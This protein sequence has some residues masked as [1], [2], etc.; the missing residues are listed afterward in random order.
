MVYKYLCEPGP[1]SSAFCPEK[2]IWAWASRSEGRPGLSRHLHGRG[3]RTR[4]HLKPEKNIS[5]R[6]K[7]VQVAPRLAE[8]SP[9]NTFQ[10]LITPFSRP[11]A[12]SRLLLPL[13]GV[14]VGR[15]P[16]AD[17]GGLGPKAKPQ[18]GW[19]QLKLLSPRSVSAF[20]L[21]LR[22]STEMF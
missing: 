12:R 6:R 9:V 8:V 4:P 22:G 3:D 5:R 10:I 1:I 14:L 21:S 16:V 11:V 7:T 2:M 15:A 18:T 13:G 19:P 20:W 17:F